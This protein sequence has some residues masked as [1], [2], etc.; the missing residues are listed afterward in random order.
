M[1]DGLRVLGV[2]ASRKGWVG[3][4]GDLKGYFGVTIGEVVERAERDGALAVVGVDI[5]IGLPVT[6]VRQADVLA[7]RVVGRR[8]SSVFATPV[9]DALLA[10]T[11]AE[12]SAL[13]VGATGKGISR[14]A[15][16]LA[17]KILEVDAWIPG[18]GCAVVEV[19]PEVS[20]ATIAGRP[21]AHPKSTWAGGEERRRLLAGVGMNVS[22]DIGPA[23]EYA[24]VDDVLDAAAAAWSANRYAEGRAVAYPETPEVVGDGRP[25]AIWA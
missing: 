18:A 14:Q 12:A 20:F 5:P 3:I 25:A 17:K 22:G 19:H 4:S 11:H 7:R 9:R 6:G 16:A 23:G 10:A 1:A 21:L 8:A 15:Y 2:D 24:A 13:N